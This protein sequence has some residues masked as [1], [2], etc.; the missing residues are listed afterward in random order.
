MN[1]AKC[2]QIARL[3]M[4]GRKA[5][6]AREKGYTFHHGLRTGSLAIRLR[7]QISKMMEVS[8]KLLFLGGLFHDVGKGR[9]PHNHS[10]ADAVARLLAEELTGEEI[11][12]VGRIV[13][14]H[15]QRKN[16]RRCWL[17]SKIVQDADLLDH[18]G[19][20]GVWLCLHYSASRD[21][22]D[23]QTLKYYNSL[24][25]QAYQVKSRKA[26]NFEISRLSFDRRISLERQYM[27]RLAVEA[28]GEL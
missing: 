18:F 5:H 3:A 12:A 20:H 28:D 25:H 16:N 6:A 10:G 13:R 7:E 27:D 17:A 26:L 4:A 14:E 24:D 9:E 15:N 11:E 8:E 1:R 22:T 21:R 19:A 2:I 23:A